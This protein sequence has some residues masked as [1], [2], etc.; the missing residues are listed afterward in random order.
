MIA[1]ADSYDATR[2]G[3]DT[4]LGDSPPDP[5]ADAAP[6]HTLTTKQRS[7]VI[8]IEQYARAT[9]ESCPASY[10]ARRL[11]I[12]HSTVQEHLTVLHRKGW[13]RTAHGP[14]ELRQRSD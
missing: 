3:A 4:R 5:P 1:G 8:I 10:L 6:L 12:H 2:A 7:L 9:G 14:A 11:R 13:I